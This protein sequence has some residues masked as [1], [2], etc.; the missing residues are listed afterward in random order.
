[1]SWPPHITVA[2]V[3]QRN[4]QFLFVEEVDAGATVYNQ[5][6]GHLEPGETLQAA[7]LRETLEETG[8]EV[9]LT[10]FIGLYQYYSEHNDTLYLR[11]CFAAEPIRQ[12]TARLD[13]DI[14]AAHWLSLEALQDLSLRSPLVR[15]CVADALARPPETLD[16]V[17]TLV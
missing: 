6:A 10:G 9:Q 2:T 15:Q 1:M 17:R 16:R 5:P 12:V 11:V 7:A 13:S 3:V 14:T 8:W 4:D